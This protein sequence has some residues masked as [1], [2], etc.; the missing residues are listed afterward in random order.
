MKKAVF[1]F[2]IFVASAC[3]LMS[4]TATTTRY[5]DCSGGS[6][7]CGFGNPQ[8]PCHCHANS[9]FAAP[10]GNPYGARFYGTAAI[11]NVLGG[12]DW[13]GP[14]CGKCFKLQAQGSTIVVKGTN[15]CP[16]PNDVC[17]GRAHFDIDAPG[18][19]FPGASISNTCSE[20]DGGEW[21]L[22]PPQICSNWPNQGC[23]CNQFHDQ[24][25]KDGCNNFKSLGWNNPSVYYEELSSCPWELQQHPPCWY[26]NGQNWPSQSPAKCSSPWAAPTPEEEQE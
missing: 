19:D 3:A 17:N 10:Q 13:L 16:P 2:G 7:G 8:K 12:A 1:I 26:D 23:D 11:S 20:V 4:G 9:M 5:W 18:Y 22:R 21:A 6:C 15:Y 25:L 24:T 14:G